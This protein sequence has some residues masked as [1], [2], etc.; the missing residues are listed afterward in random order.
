MNPYWQSKDGRHIIYH[1]DCREF[2]PN[3]PGADLIVTDPPFN[4]N[5][6]GGGIHANRSGLAGVAK[7]G[8]DEFTPGDFLPMLWKNCNHGYFFTSKN[9][10]H[11]YLS[12]MLAEQ[13]VNWDLL[14]MAKNNPIP[15]KNR[16][17][18][19]DTE[20]CIFMRGEGRYWNNEAPYDHFRKVKMVNVAPP[21]FGHPTEKPEHVISQLIEISSDVNHLVFE[22]FLGS[23][24]TMACC[25]RLGRRSIGIELTE[26]FCEVSAKRVQSELDQIALFPFA[27]HVKPK[28]DDLFSG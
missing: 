20:L 26:K 17:Y 24:T 8:I 28:Q 25:A 23:G 6:T 7:M 16:K 21:R 27:P 5:T 15:A 1:G 12:W 22:P 18:L 10:L 2:T 9:C 13:V 19:P 11:E 14:V 4:I 3:L